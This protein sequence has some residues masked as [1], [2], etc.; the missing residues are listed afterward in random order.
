MGSLLRICGIAAAL[1]GCSMAW[2]GDGVTEINQAGALAGIG[3]PDNP[4]F[5]VEITQ[6]GS[7]RLT[8]DLDATGAGIPV[9]ITVGSDNVTLDLNG[10]MVMAGSAV[11]GGGPAAVDVAGRNVLIRNGTVEASFTGINVFSQAVRIEDVRVVAGSG[12]GDGIVLLNPPGPFKG[13]GSNYSNNSSMLDRV[14]I[15]GGF[16]HNVVM[17]RS[18]T[19]R[20]SRLADASTA[21]V[22]VV[23]NVT[24]GIAADPALLTLQIEGSSLEMGDLAPAKGFTPPS[25]I[26]GCTNVAFI[27]SQFD[28][29]DAFGGPGGQFIYCIGAAMPAKGI[30]LPMA[31][32][33]VR[34]STFSNGLFGQINNMGSVVMEGSTFDEVL[35]GLMGIEIPVALAISGNRFNGSTPNPFMP[36]TKGPGASAPPFPFGIENLCGGAPC[37]VILKADSTQ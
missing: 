31:D 20:D 22:L 12:G 34:N 30:G 11:K 7:Y 1:L 37:G 14:T 25:A 10:F 26:N 18:L 29:S 27:D 33:H 15:R 5:P 9:V 36:L 32:L 3:G 16:A 35:D 21:A 4:G 8:S 17:G 28:G 6:P 13:I 23:G 2:A 19:I 24:K